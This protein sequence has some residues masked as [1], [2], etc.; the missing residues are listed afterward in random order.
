MGIEYNIRFVPRDTTEWAAFV[1]R[2]DNPVT[3]GWPAFKVELSER[4]LYFCDNGRSET[5]AV[6]LRRIID[7][8][9]KQQHSVILEEA[10]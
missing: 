4:G 8:V 3:N 6:A 1:A 2:L 9:L 5:A 10:G 7:E